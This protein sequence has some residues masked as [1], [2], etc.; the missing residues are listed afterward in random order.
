MAATF[1]KIESFTANKDEWEIYVE[2][3]E[4]YL[5]AN[6]LEEITPETDGSNANAVKQRAD[7]RRAILLSVIG[8]A[9]YTML[10]NLVSLSKPTD[11]LY[12]GLVL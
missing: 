5:T 12:D 11:K 7:K 4:V 8:P 10:K 1:G 3:L 9:T 6:D 2:R